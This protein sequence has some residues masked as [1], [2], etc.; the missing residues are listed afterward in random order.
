[1]ISFFL[2]KNLYSKSLMHRVEINFD[3]YMKIMNQKTCLIQ[4]MRR[5]LLGI[6]GSLKEMAANGK[7][8]V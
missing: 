7:L 3:V 2:D 5:F 8:A 1:M 4:E 6:Q